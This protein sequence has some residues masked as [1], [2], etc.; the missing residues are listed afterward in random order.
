[1]VF[2]VSLYAL[3]ITLPYTQNFDT[4]AWVAQLART[5]CGGTSTHTTTGCFSG[6]CAKIT[7]PTSPCTGGGIN[8]GATGLGWFDYAS[9]PTIHIRFLIKFGTRFPSGVRNGGGGLINKFI[10]LDS[11]SRIGILGLNG[12]DT[13]G[14]YVAF[15]CLDNNEVYKFASS[16]RAWIEDAA[17]KIK[18][19]QRTNEWI[20]VE[21][22]V[23]TQTDR[24]GLYIWTLDRAFN[25]V[26]IDVPSVE[27]APSGGFYMSYYN[28]YG[29]AD[30]NNYYLIDNLAVSTSYIGPPE[31]FGGPQAPAPPTNLRIAP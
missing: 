21:Y 8:G 30:P 27:S 25:G 29:A 17:L 11:P 13:D 6:G 2:P 7:P 20:A 15:G 28:S 9:T 22:W 16:G 10:L 18:D 3:G 23:N 1:M 12:S 31:G 26:Y 14:R 4:N 24:T 19:T 5:E